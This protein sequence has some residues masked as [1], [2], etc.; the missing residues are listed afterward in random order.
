MSSF[1]VFK[2]GQFQLQTLFRFTASASIGSWPRL[3]SIAQ[4]K[5]LWWQLGWRPAQFPV[6]TQWLKLEVPEKSREWRSAAWSLP[7]SSLP[8]QTLRVRAEPCF[9]TLTPVETV[10]ALWTSEDFKVFILRNISVL[11]MCT[12][13]TDSFWNGNNFRIHH[14]FVIQ[15]WATTTSLTLESIRGMKFERKPCVCI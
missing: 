14:P 10:L 7:L 1:T 3:L 5:I 13:V 15:S 2:G 8:P 12:S 4:D 11:C 9:T 6:G